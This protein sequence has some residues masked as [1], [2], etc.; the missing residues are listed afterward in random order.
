MEPKRYQ[1]LPVIVKAMQW[2]GSKESAIQIVEW[3]GYM[4]P[5]ADYF[6]IKTLSGIVKLSVGDYVIQGVAGEFYPCKS[7]IFNETYRE[8]LGMVMMNIIPCR[9][10]TF[11]EDTGYEKGSKKYGGCKID[12]NDIKL[13]AEDHTCNK[14]VEKKEV[15]VNETVEED[16]ERRR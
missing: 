2:D 14:A 4:V 12:V 5:S 8:V 13:T 16:V 9:N 10:C 1:K 15:V 6:L 11:W 3:M 7:D